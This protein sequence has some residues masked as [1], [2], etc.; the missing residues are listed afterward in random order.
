[1][2]N[3]MNQ[4]KRFKNTS[5]GLVISWWN[6]KGFWNLLNCFRLYNMKFILK[7][8]SRTV[9]Y[10]K[11]SQIL[12]STSTFHYSD[13]V[14]FCQVFTSTLLCSNQNALENIFSEASLLRHFSVLSFLYSNNSLFGCSLTTIL[15]FSEKNVFT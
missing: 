7:L 2:D 9:G 14:L 11:I 4:M 5:E 13:T 10:G 8:S 12:V 6:H 15:L 1:M 3:I